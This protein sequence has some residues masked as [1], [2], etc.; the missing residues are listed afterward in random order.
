[1]NRQVITEMIRLLLFSGYKIILAFLFLT[2]AEMFLYFA[3]FNYTLY[4][5]TVGIKLFTIGIKI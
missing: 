5:S 1:M 2:T 4:L 3:V